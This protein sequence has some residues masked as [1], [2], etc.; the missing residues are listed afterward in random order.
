MHRRTYTGLISLL[1]SLLVFGSM[2]ALTAHTHWA[3]FFPPLRQL[4]K[5]VMALSVVDYIWTILWWITYEPVAMIKDVE[6]LPVIS[7]VMP[8]YNE[9]CFVCYALQS[10]LESSYPRERLE[11][12]VVDDGSLDDTLRCITS[13]ATI[14]RKEGVQYYTH[15]HK[16]IFSKRFAIK[17]GFEVSA[18]KIIV[19]LDSDS[20][21]EKT[22]SWHW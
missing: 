9:S 13:M 14:Y 19:S 2:Y 8:V 21:L 4:L 6:V 11:V 22:R 20:V 16:Q 18:G 1:G 12:I 3:I 15:Q 17:N 7:V 5:L 10:I